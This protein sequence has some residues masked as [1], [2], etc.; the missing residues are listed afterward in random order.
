MGLVP[1]GEPSEEPD[2]EPDEEPDGE[3]S[4]ETGEETD[5]KPDGEPS[6]VVAKGSGD[7]GV[8]AVR[9]EGKWVVM[10]WR[11]TLRREQND[12]R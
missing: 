6:G 11:G 7:R 12:W 4:E 5:E 1:D 8:A 2:G 3:P 10:R 9:G